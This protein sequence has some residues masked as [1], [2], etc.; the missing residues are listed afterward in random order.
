[1]SIPYSIESIPYSVESILY[2]ESESRSIV[3]TI[4]VVGIHTLYGL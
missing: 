3:L 1:M 2:R 4:M